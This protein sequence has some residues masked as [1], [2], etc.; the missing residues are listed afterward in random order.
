LPA[1]SIY[2]ATLTRARAEPTM[3]VMRISRGIACIVAV[4]C[5][6]KSPATHSPDG[7]GATADGATPSGDAASTLPAGWLYTQGNAIFES[8]GHGSGTPWMGRGVN[9]DD[10]FLCGNNDTLYLQTPDQTL[11]NVVSGLMSGWKPSFARMS[12][13][14][15]SYQPTVSWLADAAQYATPMTHV[16]QTIAGYPGVHVL[17]TL[18]SDASMIGQ[19]TADGDA[20]ATGLP[21]DSTTTP[22]ATTFPSGTDAVYTALVDAFGSS[23]AV[24]FGLTNEPG[25]DK[26]ASP[27]ISAAMSHAVGVIRAEEDKL[28]VPHHLVSVQGNS[29][30]SEIGFY[31]TTPLPYDDV[32]YEVHGYPP[33]TE[34]YTYSHI[35]VILGEYGDL[36]SAAAFYADVETKQIPN[37][38]WDFEPFSDCTPDLLT[39]VDNSSTDLEP[40]AW[41]MTVQAYLLAHAQ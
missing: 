12:L 15:A 36:G 23:S 26:L 18:R 10:I 38:A 8:D 29:W 4:A 13:G 35:P 16:I 41:G 14:M 32:V 22:D 1:R 5:S 30:T 11:D 17:V 7:G 19:D 28:G 39:V 21:S 3:E 27:T 20:E 9:L 37:L 24:L 25:G 6:S 34:S 40:T 31:D 2:H 33:V